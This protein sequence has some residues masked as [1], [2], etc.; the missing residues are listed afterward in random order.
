MSKQVGVSNETVI[1]GLELFVWFA[2]VYN[3]VKPVLPF[4]KWG[5]II[6]VL[7]YV[8]KWFGFL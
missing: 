2:K 1:R 6:L 8:L 5:L 4:V 3:K 7:S